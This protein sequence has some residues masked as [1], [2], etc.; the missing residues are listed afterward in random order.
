M[1]DSCWT[2]YN[3]N[4]LIIFLHFHKAGG[5][6]IVDSA[7]SVTNMME[8]EWNGNPHWTT[9]EQKMFAGDAK[10]QRVPY[11]TWN[12]PQLTEWILRIKQAQNVSF[13]AMENAFWTYPNVIQDIRNMH[14]FSFDIEMITQFRNPFKR[15]VSDFFFEI[16]EKTY[17]EPSLL[18]RKNIKERLLAF[19]NG[20]MKTHFPSLQAW[21]MYIR[22]MTGKYDN[23]GNMNESD[24]EIA[25]ERLKMYDVV[26]ILELPETHVL[27]YKYG[28]QGHEYH[29]KND[30]SKNLKHLSFN[31][32]E[33]LNEFEKE[34][35]EMNELD[36][37]FYEY[38]IR[39]SRN[40]LRN[41]LFNV[42]DVH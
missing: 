8:G 12:A 26:T 6:S 36:Y 17:K 2:N 19:H 28:I 27:M 16:K 10:D 13:I 29:S 21:N 4:K 23:N 1:Q 18:K 15:F 41:S 11:W 22:I 14:N 9:T 20:R 39:V 32:T 40:M 5:T 24:L 31:D 35:E 7:R 25:K 33:I 30:G 3:Q 37:K 34:F 42:V 38:A